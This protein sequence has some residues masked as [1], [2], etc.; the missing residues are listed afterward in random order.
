MIGLY[1]IDKLDLSETGGSIPFI[2]GANVDN[3]IMCDIRTKADAEAVKDGIR[4]QMAYGLCFRGARM[5]NG[6]GRTFTAV[7]NYA[8]IKFTADTGEQS[9]LFLDLTTMSDDFDT[10]LLKDGTALNGRAALHD[11]HLKPVDMLV[12][13]EPENGPGM[14]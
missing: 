14:S 7:G 12:N 10:S 3:I 6:T 8:A 5:V 2:D 1:D 9:D 11:V 13:L 4:D